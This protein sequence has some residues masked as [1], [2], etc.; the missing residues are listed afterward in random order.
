V[1]VVESVVVVVM[2]EGGVVMGEGE[3]KQRE[4]FFLRNFLWPNIVLSLVEKNFQETS[5]R[6]KR[7]L[8]RVKFQGTSAKK[9]K[10]SQI[11]S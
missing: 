2:G 11:G 1:V 3:R 7:R 4:S 9:P 5:V 8:N 6:R 10:K